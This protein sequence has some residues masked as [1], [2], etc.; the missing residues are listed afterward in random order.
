MRYIIYAVRELWVIPRWV[1]DE[2]RARGQ[3]CR[4]TS[5]LFSLLFSFFFFQFWLFVW[6]SDCGASAVFDLCWRIGCAR[7]S[8]SRFFESLT[9]QRNVSQLCPI[10]LALYI[11]QYMNQFIN[12]RASLN[13][14]LISASAEASCSIIIS[15]RWRPPNVLPRVLSNHLRIVVRSDAHP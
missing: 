3:G 6:C 12:N 14:E 7:L 11:A 5:F 4:H 8:S 15:P 13:R 10:E 2:R 9:T 1:L